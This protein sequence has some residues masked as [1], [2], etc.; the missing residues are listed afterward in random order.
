MAPCRSRAATCATMK[1]SGPLGGGG[2]RREENERLR[3]LE[4]DSERW[5]QEQE[6]REA[7]GYVNG[8]WVGSG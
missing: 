7:N 3:T 2:G 1:V 5:F 4:S 8:W 6:R